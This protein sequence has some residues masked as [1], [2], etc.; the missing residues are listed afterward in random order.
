MQHVTPN[1]SKIP[2]GWADNKT[3]NFSPAPIKN[4][5]PI[6]YLDEA[7]P[8]SDCDKIIEYFSASENWQEVSVQGMTPDGSA[9][10]AE[11]G[12]MRTTLFNPELAA[13]LFNNY[14][15][16]QMPSVYK[17]NKFTATDC[18]QDV[19]DGDDEW[20]LVGMSPML[21]YM[22]YE[23]D[24]QHY[25]HYDAGY[26]YP[27]GIHRTLKSVVIY[28]TTNETGRTR[29]VMDGQ[30]CLQ[31]KDRDH[32]D[33]SAPAT[34]SEVY[35]G[36]YPGKGNILIFDHRLCHD[37]SQFQP[38]KEGDKRIIIRGDLIYRLKK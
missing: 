35:R 22:I 31:T 27:D 7:I 11:K 5:E 3:I 36:Y 38:R 6:N 9:Y 15:K 26:F 30:E 17:T 34:E 16:D 2:G 28:L 29:F 24:G 25:P 13:Q 10:N 4:S 33:W 32:Q 23:K 20:E 37:V 12:S 1:M 8:V 19:E 14:I 18:W 21:R